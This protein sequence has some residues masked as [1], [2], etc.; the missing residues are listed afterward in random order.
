MSSPHHGFRSLILTGEKANSERMKLPKMKTETSSHS[1][2]LQEY[3]FLVEF[4]V[5]SENSPDKMVFRASFILNT[6]QIYYASTLCQ[7]L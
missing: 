3:G 6:I 5:G 1:Y 4:L 2:F 7:T